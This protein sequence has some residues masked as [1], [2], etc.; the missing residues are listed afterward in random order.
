MIVYLSLLVAI[1]GVLAYA[2]SQNAKVQEL[3][4][5]AWGMGLLAFLLQATKLIELVGK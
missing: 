1:I 5:I 2:L 3:G 4:R